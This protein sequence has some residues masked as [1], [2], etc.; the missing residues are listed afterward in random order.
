MGDVRDMQGERSTTED[1]LWHAE[2]GKPEV[3][4]I[5]KDCNGWNAKQAD[6][7]K[8]S[9]AMMVAWVKLTPAEREGFKQAHKSMSQSD[10]MDGMKCL[11][12][13]KKTDWETSK[14]GSLPAHQSLSA[15]A[16]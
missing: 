7:K 3:R 5:C 16:M 15:T 13:L 9:P 1:R 8:K 2:S 14:K 6:I 10:I 12:E 11:I 4:D